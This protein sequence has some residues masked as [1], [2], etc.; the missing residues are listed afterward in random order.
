MSLEERA[1]QASESARFRLGAPPGRID[2]FDAIT[3]LGIRLLRYPVPENALEGAYLRTRDVSYVLVNSSAR[4][5]RQRF[6]A[7]HE[8]GHHFLHPNTDLEHYDA[9]LNE[10]EDRAAN[11]FAA[12]FLMDTE[13]VRSVASSESN[14]LRRALAVRYQFDVSLQAASIHLCRLGLMDGATM[15]KI[16]AERDRAGSILE[17]ART[18]GLD[19][20]PEEAPDHAVDMGRDYAAALAEIRDAGFLSDERFTA[21]L[22]PFSAQSRPSAA[23]SAQ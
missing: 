9:T 11:S 23:S 7:A 18:V 19:V 1:R 3:R 12:Y 20:P 13:S 15:S 5:A 10:P 2:V 14:P 6:T 17:L 21:M 8:L 4:P 16:L 22:E